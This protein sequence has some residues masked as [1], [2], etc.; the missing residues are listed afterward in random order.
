L[1]GNHGVDDEGRATGSMVIASARGS[2]K[3]PFF[4]SRLPR[5]VETRGGDYFFVPGMTALRMIGEGS[6]DPT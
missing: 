5:F 2:G 3:P 4:C 1:V 6:I